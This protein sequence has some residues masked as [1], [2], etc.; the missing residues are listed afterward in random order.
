MDIP[1]VLKVPTNVSSAMGATR[2]RIARKSDGTP[3]PQSRHVS[4]KQLSS[5]FSVAKAACQRGCGRSSSK[6]YLSI[7]KHSK[8]CQFCK[9]TSARHSKGLSW[10]SYSALTLSFTC[11]S[12]HRAGLHQ[13][14]ETYSL[15]HLHFGPQ[16][17]QWAFQASVLIN[18]SVFAKQ[19]F[20]TNGHVT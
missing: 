9:L 3:L 4:Q 18:E 8:G 16:F 5:K 13:L 10:R 7:T 15:D 11:T 20:C 14:Q 12:H 1:D 2:C 19:I 17:F 6:W